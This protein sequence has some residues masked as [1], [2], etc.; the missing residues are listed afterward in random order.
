MTIILNLYFRKNR[1]I[2]CLKLTFK[3]IKNTLMIK[4]INNLYLTSFFKKY[5][6]YY[7]NKILKNN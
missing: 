2:H 4:L 1:L 5:I 7:K 3:I 6:I